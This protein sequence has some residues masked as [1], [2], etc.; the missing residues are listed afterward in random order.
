MK[1]DRVPKL[2]DLIATGGPRGMAD[3]AV[4]ARVRAWLGEHPAMTASVRPTVGPL[5]VETDEQ[6]NA[7]TATWQANARTVDA[8]A[9]ITAAA[10][11]A[12]VDVLRRRRLEKVY[13]QSALKSWYLR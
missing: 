11:A 2:R 9:S 1:A 13:R 12:V 3:P 8:V 4:N 6:A 5:R 7:R 10:T